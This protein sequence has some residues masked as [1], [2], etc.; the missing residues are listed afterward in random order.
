M[1]PRSNLTEISHK[2]LSVPPEF[3]GRT[4]QSHLLAIRRGAACM[5]ASKSCNNLLRWHPVVAI[6]ILPPIFKPPCRSIYK[7]E[8]NRIWQVWSHEIRSFTRIRSFP[9][10]VLPPSMKVRP[11]VGAPPTE[12]VIQNPTP[13]S[14]YPYIRLICLAA[15]F[16]TAIEMVAQRR[17]CDTPCGASRRGA[18]EG[19]FSPA[20]S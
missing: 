13:P 11:F 9:R 19:V 16:F 17:H 18:T 20:N 1:K 14:L 8:L 7:G 12:G 15:T 4:F 3:F 10:A 6:A 2:G 5:M